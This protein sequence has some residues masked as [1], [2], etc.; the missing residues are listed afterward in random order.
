[1]WGRPAPVAYHLHTINTYSSASET[2][3]L[4]DWKMVSE[5]SLTFTCAELFSLD[6]SLADWWEILW[7]GGKPKWKMNECNAG[8][9]VTS[10]NHNSVLIFCLGLHPSIP[11]YVTHVGL[12]LSYQVFICIRLVALCVCGSLWGY[13]CVRV[14]ACTEPMYWNWSH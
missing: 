7:P 9:L 10:Q 2:I 4:L 13:L 14:Y 3:H 11:V 12:D 1:M 8:A 5:E 6:T